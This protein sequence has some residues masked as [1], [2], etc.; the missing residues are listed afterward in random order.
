[1]T[2]VDFGGEH[3]FETVDVGGKSIGIHIEA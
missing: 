3:A 1:V 2:T